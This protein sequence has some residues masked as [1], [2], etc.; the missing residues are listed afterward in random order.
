M[1]G[2]DAGW[3]HARGFRRRWSGM[4]VATGMAAALYLGALHVRSGELTVGELLVVMAYMAQLSAP[5]E[6]ITRSAW[7]NFRDRSPAPPGRSRCST[8]YRTSSSARTPD[9]SVAPQAR[10]DS[11]D[12][13][14]GYET[15]QSVLHDISFEVA[16]GTR[17]G[18]A[19]PTGAGKTT[20]VN[21]LT[22]FYDP[23]G[24]QDP[25]R[26][27]RLRDYKLDD[28]RNSSR[29]CCRSRCC[30]RRASPRTS[31]MHGPA[32]RFDEIVA[33]AK[34]A[35]AHEFI[36]ALP[37]G[38]DTL[39]GERGLRLSGGERQRISLARA[40]LKDAPILSWTSRPARWTSEPR[41]RS[42]RRWSG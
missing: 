9:R 16:P 6:T 24:R 41:R 4:T 28:V 39:V 18:I 25:A 37:D 27:R 19:G 34:A 22:R 20:L 35:S 10:F 1:S 32:R 17:V 2:P 26:R 36:T 14:F 33:A 15:G 7:R 23:T 12:V 30:S 42:W 8:R 3:R 21:L 40:F 31:R 13:S 11:S 5:V 38:Y 29:S